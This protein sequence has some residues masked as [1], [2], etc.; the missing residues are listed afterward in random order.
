MKIDHPIWHLRMPCSVCGQGSALAL[1]AC[2]TCGD[3]VVVCDEEGSYLPDPR[4]TESR[5]VSSLS[6]GTTKC[7]NCRSVLV[8]QFEPAA[9]VAIFGTRRYV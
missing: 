2:P 7:A 1:S 5:D 4:A 3:I 6:W 9:G 8:A